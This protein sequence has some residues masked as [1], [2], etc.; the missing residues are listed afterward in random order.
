MLKVTYKAKC[1]ICGNP[2]TV[3]IDAKKGWRHFHCDECNSDSQNFNGE[4]SMK[5]AVIKPWIKNIITTKLDGVAVG[6]DEYTRKCK[7]N[8]EY[9]KSNLNRRELLEGLAEE[10]A[11]LAKAALKCIRAERLNN[12][13]TPMKAFDAKR[14]LDEELRDVMTVAYIMGILPA[15]F[16][17]D[18][19]KI[20][21]WA[22]RIEKAKGEK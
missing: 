4:K 18:P 10:A 3:L 5:L 12:N 2:D 9:I 20:E 1:P 22:L 17:P 16:W 8:T 21:R 11:E 19:E 7:I 13:P 15:V 14:N 6:S